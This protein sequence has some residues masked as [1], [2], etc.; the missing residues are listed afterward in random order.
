MTASNDVLWTA[1][2]AAAATGGTCT[3]DW[4]ATG[5]SID[6]RTVREG[7]L[8]VALKGPNF[9][10]HAYVADALA[11]GAVAA[12]VAEA[13]AGAADEARLLRVADTM[14]ALSGLARAARA[15]SHAKV[16]AVTG[17][18]GKTGTKEML[19]LCLAAQ[20]RTHATEGN[21]NNHWGLPLTLARMPRDAKYAVLEMGMNHAGELTPLSV[22]ARPDVAVVTNVE[23]VHSA[24]FAS[25]EAIADAKAEIFAGLAGGGVAVLNGDSPYFSRIAAA[26][27]D[28]R[29]ISFGESTNAD[30]RLL[31]YGATGTGGAVSIDLGGQALSYTIGAAGRHWALN[32]LAVL[33]AVRAAG[34][35]PL[36]AAGALN[37]MRAPKGRGAGLTVRLGR[38]S[39]TVV[40][41]SYNASPA[42]VRAALDVL[43]AMPASRRVAVLGDMLELGA[44]SAVRHAALADAV[45]AAGVDLLYTCGENMRHLF[46]AVAQPLRGGH[47]ANSENLKPMVVGAVRAG[48]V[49]VVKGSAGSRMGVVVDA[50]LALDSNG[51]G[52][53]KRAANGH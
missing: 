17:S 32:S 21:L 20:G 38:E 14:V 37:G 18:V 28:A 16:I 19:R 42:S 23:A 52:A 46:D 41:E 39:F 48:D 25:V 7:D 44:D 11:K 30:V 10:G 53:A 36:I 3:G 49:V 33:A 24:H 9:D 51:N 43:G 26:A 5:V 27:G 40:D 12:V 29:V 2:E 1:D 8:F 50:L 35:D 22:L 13:P 34:A 45:A 15:R 6:S 47:A 31:A 4:R